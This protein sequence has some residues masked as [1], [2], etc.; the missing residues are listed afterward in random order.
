MTDVHPAAA[1]DD[2]GGAEATVDADVQR[3]LDELEDRWR[4][5]LADLDN[6]RKRTVREMERLRAGERAA[7][8]SQWL[9]VVDNLDLALE[10]AGGDGEALVE[11]VR[12]VR[13]QAAAVL[14]ALGFPRQDD[15]GRQFDPARHE[16]VGTEASD[17]VPP[18]T[19]IRV[20]RPGY[21]DDERLVRPAA[22]VVA[23]QE[24]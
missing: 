3:R 5:A 14:A 12:A 10:H 21:G 4:R 17:S 11:G 1:S 23:T 2:A 24:Q 22:V 6:Y 18:G 15:L 20:V 8:V 13:D 19:V 9:P 7:V 16:A